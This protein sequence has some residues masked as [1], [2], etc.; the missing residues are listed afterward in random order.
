MA[1]ILD[2]ASLNSELLACE[3]K[4]LQQ[5]DLRVSFSLD[6]L[7]NWVISPFDIFKKCM[8]N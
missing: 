8:L 5:S 1:T 3:D 2:A 4:Q 7:F 6:V